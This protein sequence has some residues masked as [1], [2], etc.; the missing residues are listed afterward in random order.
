MVRSNGRIM[1]QIEWRIHWQ[2]SIWYALAAQLTRRGSRKDD[3]LAVQ[4][5]KK[6]PEL[7]DAMFDYFRPSPKFIIRMLERLATQPEWEPQ[8]V[9]SEEQIAVIIAEELVELPLSR[10]Y[11][12]RLAPRFQRL[13]AAMIEAVPSL[14]DEMVLYAN[15]LQRRWESEGP[16]FLDEV[17][18]R[19]PINW[20]LD[21]VKIFPVFPVSGGGGCIHSETHSVAIEAVPITFQTELP[22]TQRLTWL[23]AQVAV[24]EASPQ[25]SPEFRPLVKYALIPAVLSAVNPESWNQRGDGDIYFAMQS[26]CPEF[27]EDPLDATTTLW[28]WWQQADAHDGDWLHGL[29]GLKIPPRPW[30]N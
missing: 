12:Q 21:H 20:Q 30:V 18:H 22:E 16:G 14:S 4:A 6:F 13:F 26:W 5:A 11:I 23:I 8:S 17:Q 24:H 15:V 1:I 29:K 27:G 10:I 9:P 19:I 3:R 2:N 7:L 25:L 28:N